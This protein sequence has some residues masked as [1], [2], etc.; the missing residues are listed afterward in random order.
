MAQVNTNPTS[1]LQNSGG[2]LNFSPVELVCEASAARRSY[3]GS[4]TNQQTRKAADDASERDA[5]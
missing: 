4:A 5:I 1:H 2:R 3:V